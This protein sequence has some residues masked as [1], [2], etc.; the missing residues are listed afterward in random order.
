MSNYNCH[1]ALKPAKKAKRKTQDHFT[2]SVGSNFA[3]QVDEQTYDIH[4]AQ[5]GFAAFALYKCSAIIVPRF[6]YKQSTE[7]F[8]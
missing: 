6:G 4:T 8:A 2:G 3:P 1:S 5:L 7:L